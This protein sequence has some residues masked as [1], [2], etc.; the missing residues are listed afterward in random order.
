M[1]DV[2]ITIGD[3]PQG[4]TGTSA[5][6]KVAL[7]ET[8]VAFDLLYQ[9]TDNLYYKAVDTSAAAA[10]ATYIAVQPGDASDSISA[11]ALTEGGLVEFGSASLTANTIY[12]VS[13]TAGKLAPL[14]DKTSSEFLRLVGWAKSTTQLHLFTF[15]GG[16]QVA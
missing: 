7:G 2:S 5:H 12:C 14:S 9:H 1:A 13:S 3:M 10:T 4:S 16:V 15:G 6:S 11:I 8:V